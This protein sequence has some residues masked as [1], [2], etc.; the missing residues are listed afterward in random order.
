MLDI[1]SDKIERMVLNLVDNALKYAPNNSTVKVRAITGDPDYVRLEIVD[2]GPGIPDEYKKRLFDRFVQVEG[3]KSVRRG[4]GLGLTFCKL[5]TEAHGGDI[6]VADNPEGGGSIFKVT[7][8]IAKLSHA[9][10]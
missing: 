4:V 2:S 8:P 5:V 7:L 6:W 9:V 1:D 3:R 10:E